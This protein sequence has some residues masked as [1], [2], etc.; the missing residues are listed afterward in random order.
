MPISVNVIVK[1]DA[2]HFIFTTERRRTSS[3]TAREEWTLAAGG[4]VF[5]ATSLLPWYPF[6]QSHGVPAASLD[7]LTEYVPIDLS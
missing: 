7:F 5:T 1:S 2:V 4:N 6:V 3:F